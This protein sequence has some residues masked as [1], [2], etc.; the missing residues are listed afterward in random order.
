M[1]RNHRA[2]PTGVGKSIPA[3]ISASCKPGHPHGCGEIE[4]GAFACRR[5]PGPSPRVW[6][7]HR[8]ALS[9]ELHRRAIPTG[10]GKS[11]GFA[12]SSVG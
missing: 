8:L 11:L 12:M 7:N 6:G 2:I 1:L 5:D 9:V 3:S 10:V 4:S